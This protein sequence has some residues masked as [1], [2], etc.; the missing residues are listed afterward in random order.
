MIIPQTQ[1]ELALVPIERIVLT[2]HQPR[3]PE[4]VLHYVALLSEPQNAD[5][6][7]GLIHLMSCPDGAHYTILDGHHRFFACAM[8]GRSEVLAL[9]LTEP[10]QPGYTGLCT[11]ETL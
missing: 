5:K 10:G 8:A 9:I 3:Y 1:F 11:V 6:H 4:Q 2:E 7:P